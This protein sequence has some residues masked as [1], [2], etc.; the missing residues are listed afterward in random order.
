MA[1]WQP[2]CHSVPTHIRL[3]TSIVSEPQAF[4]I[5]RKV[6]KVR[7]FRL[8]LH[9]S[10]WIYVSIS[11]SKKMPDAKKTFFQ[12]RC[13]WPSTE[14]SAAHDMVKA[15]RGQRLK[16]KQ[17]ECNDSQAF[18]AGTLLHS[19]PAETSTW[20]RKAGFIRVELFKKRFILLNMEE[21]LLK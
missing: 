4:S 21:F 7:V 11:G 2:M 12:F 15:H 8:G 6:T 3:N 17:Q 19:I 5:P 10:I 13:I 18:P 14:V 20:L 1:Q 16:K 9:Q